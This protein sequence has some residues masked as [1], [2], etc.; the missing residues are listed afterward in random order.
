MRRRQR[1]FYGTPHLDFGVQDR[2]CAE[3]H[4]CHPVFPIRAHGQEGQV[5]GTY[6]R[7]AGGEHVN[8][9]GLRPRHHHGSPCQPDSGVLRHSG[10]QLVFG[11]S[12]DRLH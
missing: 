10:R 12:Y 9:G 7:Q 11:A 4:C 6:Y 8:G 5:A 1:Q 2:L 3:D